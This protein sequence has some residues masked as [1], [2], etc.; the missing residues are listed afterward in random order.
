MSLDV[1]FSY[2]P[3]RYQS[4]EGAAK[5]K[6]FLLHFQREIDYVDSKNAKKKNGVCF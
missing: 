2:T 1:S 4:I 6:I 5:K 3:A